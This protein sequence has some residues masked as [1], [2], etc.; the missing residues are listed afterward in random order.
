M[1]P[2][3]SLFAALMNYGAN[4]K[5]K[6]SEKNHELRKDL[7]KMDLKPKELGKKWDHPML[8]DTASVFSKVI[9]P[10]PKIAEI[11]KFEKKK[12]KPKKIATNTGTASFFNP[13]G[14]LGKDELAEQKK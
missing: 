10:S 4:V 8:S 1:N 5:D 3:V 7:L 11:S 13:E 6:Y 9:V 12:A 14:T 2:R